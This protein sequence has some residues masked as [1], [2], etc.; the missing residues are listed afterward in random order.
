MTYLLAIQLTTDCKIVSQ[1]MTLNCLLVECFQ[2]TAPL[3]GFKV[4]PQSLSYSHVLGT[5]LQLLSQPT[6]TLNTNITTLHCA[7]HCQRNVEDIFFPY[8]NTLHLIHTVHWL[9]TTMDPALV[10]SIYRKL[11][12]IIS[13]KYKLNILSPIDIAHSKGSKGTYCESF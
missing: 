4:K 12:D 3:K 7:T 11:K 9:F 6:W 2:K 13:E 1:R 10:M 5:Y 8:K